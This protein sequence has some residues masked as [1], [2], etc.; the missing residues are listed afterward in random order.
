[1]DLASSGF[2]TQQPKSSFYN[3]A[4]RVVHRPPHMSLRKEAKSLGWQSRPS[5]IWP[6][7]LSDLSQP[8]RSLSTTAA[9]LPSAP[10]ECFCPGCALCPE[11]SSLKSS[12]VLPL[13]LNL[14]GNITSSVRLLELLHFNTAPPRAPLRVLLSHTTLLSFFCPWLLSPFITLDAFP[15]LLYVC[16]I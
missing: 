5:P 8:C 9:L 1:M 16:F 6:L 3:M 12:W 7:H 4:L 11:C 2:T 14:Y 15:S 10:P 13:P